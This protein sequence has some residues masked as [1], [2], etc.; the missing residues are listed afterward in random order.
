MAGVSTS[1][2]STAAGPDDVRLTAWL[3][4]QVQ[5]VG[6]RWWVRAR[7]LELGLT[8]SA[9]NRADGRVEV[10]V[11]G[12]RRAAESLLGLLSPDHPGAR[13]GRVDDLTLRWDVARGGLTGFVER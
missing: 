8:G 4:G 1:H 2:D 12:T 9:A 3:T 5:G 11:E 7:A 10:V 6:M 13:P